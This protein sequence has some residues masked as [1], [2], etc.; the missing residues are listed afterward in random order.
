[1]PSNFAPDDVEAFRKVLN[2]RCAFSCTCASART[3][4]TDTALPGSDKRRHERAAEAASLR[5]ARGR[6]AKADAVELSGVLTHLLGSPSTCLTSYARLPRSA[7][8]AGR[9]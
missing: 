8:K 5:D 3:R 4:A 2:V 9:S 1:M 7:R 6:G